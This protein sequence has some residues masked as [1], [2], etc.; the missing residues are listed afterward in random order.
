MSVIYLMTEHTQAI[1]FTNWYQEHFFSELLLPIVLSLSCYFI[2]LSGFCLLN[3][4]KLGLCYT[5]YV[6]TVMSSL[7]LRTTGL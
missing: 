3:F 4:T 7:K 5:H 6:A 2:V 1:L